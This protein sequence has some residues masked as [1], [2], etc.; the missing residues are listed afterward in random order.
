[1]IGF[2]TFPE[3]NPRRHDHRDDDIPARL[4]SQSHGAGTFQMNYDC[5]IA[6]SGF[7]TPTMAIAARYFN[8]HL[9]CRLCPGSPSRYRRQELLPSQMLAHRRYDQRHQVVSRRGPSN[10]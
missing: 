9:L 3:A 8:R 7:F 4:E 1:M 2:L 6:G 10:A 5:P